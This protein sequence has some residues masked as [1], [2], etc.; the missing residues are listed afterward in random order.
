M[1]TI[2]LKNFRKLRI[3]HEEKGFTLLEVVI[4]VVLISLVAAALAFGLSAASKALLRNDSRE[5]AK[6]LAETQMEFV[7]EQPFNP[8]SGTSVYTAAPIPAAQ[9]GY[10][11]SINVI[12]GSSLTPPRDSYMQEIIITVTG[13]GNKTYPSLVDYKVD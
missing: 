3:V 10:S 4:S 13:P 8:G 7:K 5:I 1:F 11:V 2:R 6:N 12:D 9:S